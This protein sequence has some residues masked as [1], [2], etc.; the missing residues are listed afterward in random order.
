MDQIC[1]SCAR[2]HAG[3]S[4][5]NRLCTNLLLPPLPPPVH[6]QEHHKHRDCLHR[7]IFLSP[8][9]IEKRARPATG[10]CQYPR[11]T[12]VRVDIFCCHRLHLVA[13]G[14]DRDVAA[15]AAP[16]PRFD[17]RLRPS[18]GATK[19]EEEEEVNFGVGN[20]RRRRRKRREGGA[21][22]TASAANAATVGRGE[23]TSA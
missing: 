19:R 18:C 4:R 6:R 22:V 23:C 2:S 10:W 3:A 1:E 11:I 16:G 21:D 20:A 5:S 13:A 9:R 8:A 7:Q 15:A 12:C 14:R 17:S